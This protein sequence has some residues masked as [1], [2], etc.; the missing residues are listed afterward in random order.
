MIFCSGGDRRFAALAVQA[1]FRYGAQLPNTVHPALGPLY[2]A[3]QDWK[4]P[5]RAAYVAALRRW[6]PALATVLDWERDEQLPE[7]LSWA[8]DAA[9]YV[10]TLVLIPKVVGG[11]ER[12]PRSVGGRPVRL[13]YSA[14]SSYGGTAVPIWEFAGWPVHVLGGAPHRQM[15]LARYLDV[16]SC[17]GNMTRRMAV[18][19]CAFWVP[20]TARYAKNRW[21]PQLQEDNA[22]QWGQDAPHEAFRRSCA[23]I[24]AA[25]REWAR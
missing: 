12:L 16:R 2:F 19:H 10:E 21:W 17:D 3:D 24:L 20:G 4:R 14:A 8:E 25:W 9:P 13:G 22:E 7:V 6:R 18:T 15:V 5:D 11:V 1:G 23:N